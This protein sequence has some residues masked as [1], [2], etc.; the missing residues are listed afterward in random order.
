MQKYSPRGFTLIELLIVIGIIAILA[1]ATII[2]INPAR[3]FA[4]ARDSQRQTNI[5]TILDAVGQRLADN[6]GVFAG[7]SLNCPSLSVG[8][9]YDIASATSTA[10]TTADLSC[11]VPLYIATALPVDPNAPGAHWASSADYDT[12]YA[13]SLD[14][15]GRFTVSAPF[16]E[17]SSTTLTR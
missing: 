8:I 16:A 14:Q 6:K 7:G 11:L 12:D 5:E 4:Q 10:S 3:Q 1:A 15:N 9:T 13:V 2:A 17:L